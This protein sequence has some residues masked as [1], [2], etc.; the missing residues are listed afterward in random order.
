MRVSFASLQTLVAVVD[1]GSFS[2]A[3]RALG[4]T[5]SAVSQ[6]IAALE[7]SLGLQ[8]FERRGRSV[9]PTEAARHLHDRSEELVGLLTR[10]EGEVERLSAGQAGRIRIGSFASADDQILS[11]A[12]A[13][14]LVRRRDIEVRL[15]E[16]E[17][18]QLLPEVIRGNLDVALAF[19]YDIASPPW[20]TDLH[21][22]PLLREPLH[23]VVARS[24]RFARRDT[25]ELAELREESWAANRPNTLA[26]ACL[27]NTAAAAGFRPH[28]PFCSNNFDA[29]LGIAREG[30]A[31]ALVPGLAVPDDSQLVP[32]PISGLPYRTVAAVTRKAEP[33]ALVAAAVRTFQDAAAH[34][35]KAR[36]WAA[37]APESLGDSPSDRG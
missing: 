6:Q 31:V 8:L 2:G 13:R 27:L 10:V 12:L 36:G 16:G 14:L 18:F 25:V 26:H 23:V 30:L 22:I 21:A 7:R 1:E 24:H 19:R 5:Q 32:L 9:H 15:E 35:A 20:P 28:I 4:Y 3:A 33:S 34:V 37:P 29:V 11:P 17:P